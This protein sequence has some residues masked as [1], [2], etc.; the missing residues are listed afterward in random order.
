MVSAAKLAATSSF[1]IT[2]ES[3]EAFSFTKGA[4]SGEKKTSTKEK[5]YPMKYFYLNDEK[6]PFRFRPIT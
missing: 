3:K 4:S 1:V 5:V 2:S 6:V